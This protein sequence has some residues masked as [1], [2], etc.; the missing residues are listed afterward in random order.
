ML[1][2]LP[3]FSNAIGIDLGTANTLI[4]LRGKGIV[5][6]E[7]SVVAIHKESKRP[8]AVGADA[9]RMLGRTPGAIE[10]VRP[11]KDGIIAD[12][13]VS[14]HMLRFFIGKVAR[15]AILSR[16]K[17]VVAVPY[18]ISQ[19]SERAL[20][21]STYRAGADD[22]ETIRE[23][24]AAALGSGLP[25][26]E[27]AA[28]MIVDIGGGTTEVA[29]LS[30]GNIACAKSL[31][32]GGDAFDASIIERIKVMYNLNIGPRMAEDIKIKIGS[33]VPLK[34]ELRMEVKG[35]DTLRGVPHSI[36]IGSEEVRDAL[37][38]SLE[39]ITTGVRDVLERCAPELS[40]DLVDRGIA[41]AGGGALL[42][43]VDRLISDVTGIPV[44]VADDPM[45]AVAN[46]AGIFLENKNWRSR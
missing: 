7:P 31:R 15:K 18:E 43:G 22:V 34:Q 36:I 4:H 10:A 6:D 44:F 8:I 40:A 14:E 19:A 37:K 33:A 29:I 46:G 9:K 42:R 23:P 28:S 20:T 39:A 11:M 27:P 32:V 12:P 45:R 21:D 2:R 1:K 13:D 17:V 38:G 24:V 26:G 41:L 35:R 5:L 16:L 30:L 25:V 3:G